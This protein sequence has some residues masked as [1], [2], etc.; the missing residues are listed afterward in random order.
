MRQMPQKG[1]LMALVSE[2]ENKLDFTILVHG[3]AAHGSTPHLGKD[4]IV[5]A[6]A[7][8]QAL[9]TLVSRVNNPLRP[10]VLALENVKAGKQF[11]IICD[12]V[13]LQGTLLGYDEELLA[14]MAEKLKRMAEL[15]AE[16]FA[17]KSEVRFSSQGGIC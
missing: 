8:I 12:Q 3:A 5:A 9:Q 14:E 2:K 15:T 13:Q 6:A 11:N 10:L 16:T 7:I 4:A 17:C 1:V